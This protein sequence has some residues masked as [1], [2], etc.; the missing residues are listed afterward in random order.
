M[1][2][3]YAGA[4]LLMDA[5]AVTRVERIVLA[6]AFGSQ[7]DPLYAMVLGMLPDCDPAAWPATPPVPVPSWPCSI[8]MPARRLRPP[9]GGSK[10]ETAVAPA[11]QEHF[12]AAMAFPHGLD[13]FPRLAQAIDLPAPPTPTRRR[14]RR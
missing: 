9:C 3:L 1:A 6:G 14:R 13:N 10:I 8:A 12:V 11:F 7:I 4:R 5:L 2:A